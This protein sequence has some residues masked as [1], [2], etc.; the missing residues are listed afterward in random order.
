MARM[1]MLSEN[2]LNTTTQLKLDS[3][4]DLASY[5]FD[6]S[7][8]LGYSSNGYNSNTSTVISVEFSSPVVLSN[9]ILQNHNLKAFRLFYNSV[10]ANALVP[11]VSGNSATSSYFFFNSV[12]V[13]SVQLQMD[14]TIAGGVEKTVG[15]FVVAE[16]Q[17]QFERNPSVQKWRPTI[18]RK[19][20]EHEMPGGGTA[21]FNI[22]DNYRASLSWKFITT[23]FRDA[24]FSVF[25]TADPLYF[26][27]FPTTTG[28]DGAA[29]ETVWV[30]DFD[31]MHATN[32]KVQG[33]SGSILL[34]ETPGR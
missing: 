29:Y 17:V 5:L 19:Q 33:F 3:G 34:K 27:P 10:T 24:L 30:G 25:S 13:S 16:R 32:D 28:W 15:E 7:V 18:F 9:V 4:T 6:R 2:R 23:S 26:L 1:E 11:A 22:R 14:T 8:A 31:F 21:I 12:T 20:I